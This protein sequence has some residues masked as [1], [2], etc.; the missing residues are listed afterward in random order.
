MRIKQVQFIAE[1]EKLNYLNSITDLVI[2]QNLK[3]II[4]SDN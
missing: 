3:G 1:K 2:Q 4:C